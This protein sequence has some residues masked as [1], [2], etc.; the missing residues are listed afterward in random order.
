MSA[1]RES[2]RALLCAD[3]HAAASLKSGPEARRSLRTMGD[4]LVLPGTC[5]VV[6]HRLSAAAQQRGWHLSA[7]AIAALNLVLFS[8]EI[9]PRARIGPGLVLAHPYGVV[10]G[11]ATLGRD[12]RLMGN[13]RVGGMPV[14]GP[15]PAGTPVVGDE[16]WLF[17]GAV[18][19]GEVRVGAR[20]VV[21]TNAVV[22]R[23]VPADA[24]VFGD[25]ARA[26]RYRSAPA[27]G[28][29]AS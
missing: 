14:D 20:A 3:L 7:T 23:D 2:L 18:V 19:V 25:P 16:C 28:V 10:I 22:S 15:G 21:S 11:P 27:P 17:D 1:G 5:A 24:V 9:D 29:I 6:L 13:V 8:T 4:V 26:I 12:A